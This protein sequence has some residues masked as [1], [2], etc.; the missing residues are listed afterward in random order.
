MNSAFN[1]PAMNALEVEHLRNLE[2]NQRHEVIRTIG[3]Y[4]TMG[5]EAY[6]DRYGYRA[7]AEL[8]D[9]AKQSNINFGIEYDAGDYASKFSNELLMGIPG[10]FDSDIADMSKYSRGAGMAAAGMGGM[11]AGFLLPTGAL[12]MGLKASTLTA[13]GLR[14][15]KAVRGIAKGL[16]LS[17]D[18]AR[19]IAH[20]SDD[21]VALARKQGKAVKDLARKDIQKAVGLEGE[22]L[23]AGAAKRAEVES[24]G[25]LRRLKGAVSNKPIGAFDDVLSTGASKATKL[26]D[27]GK[28]RSLGKKTLRDADDAGAVMHDW[29]KGL[30]KLTERS[31]LQ[32]VGLPAGIAATR[33]AISGFSE[34][35]GADQRDWV[36]TPNAQQK[37]DR[38]LES[39]GSG[40]SRGLTEG[41]ATGLT[42]GAGKFLSPLASVGVGTGAT[43]LGILSGSDAVTSMGLGVLGAGLIP[44]S[45]LGS[46]ISKKLKPKLTK[47]HTPQLLLGPGPTPKI[48]VPTTPFR[49]GKPLQLEASTTAG[50]RY[51]MGQGTPRPP[52][53]HTGSNIDPVHAARVGDAQSIIEMSNMKRALATIKEDPVLTTA[54]DLVKANMKRLRL[55]SDSINSRELIELVSKVASRLT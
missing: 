35:Y 20:H 14:S 40:I 46:G 53:P 15:A 8:Y 22:K 21:L 12:G 29:V 11:A 7:E 25:V 44:R 26:N 23:L 37:L 39:V 3:K 1:D 52:Q 16:N 10:F 34:A 50:R 38:A 32:R 51:T 5:R 24:L 54:F 2:A 45:T 4:R 9:A 33:G 18:T 27:V 55:S 48:K 19:A 41:L 36:R 13:K 31:M 42:A 49:V 30:N 28:L 47:V 17:D 6:V 43:G